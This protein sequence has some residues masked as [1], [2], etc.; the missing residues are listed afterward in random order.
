MLTPIYEKGEEEMPISYIPVCMLSQKRKI[1]KEAKGNALLIKNGFAGQFGLERTQR[2][3]DTYGCGNFDKKGLN[4]I[5]KLELINE[6]DCINRSTLIPDFEKR[7]ETQLVKMLRACL[8]L[9]KIST[10]GKTLGTE[11]TYRLG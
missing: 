3:H 10:K 7:M 1:I 2:T 11:A 6:Y 8:Q 4:K 5:V 9:M